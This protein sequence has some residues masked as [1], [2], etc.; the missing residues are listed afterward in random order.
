LPAGCCCAGTRNAK[1]FK[2]VGR[3]PGEEAVGEEEGVGVRERRESK[4]G[5]TASTVVPGKAHGGVL[6]RQEARCE[7]VLIICWFARS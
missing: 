6:P 4:Q 2:K 3:D 1:G 7:A 5:V